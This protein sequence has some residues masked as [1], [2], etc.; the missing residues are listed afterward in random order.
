MW[1]YSRRYVH[2]TSAWDVTTIYHYKDFNSSMYFVV[3]I[4]TARQGGMGSAG[5]SVE[6]WNRHSYLNYQHHLNTSVW[7]SRSGPH[8]EQAKSCIYFFV[9]HLHKTLTIHYISHKEC[10]IRKYSNHAN[11]LVRMFVLF[12]SKS[13]TWRITQEKYPS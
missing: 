7:L 4:V 12:F 3:S 10:S 11:W 8:K 6:N 1:S 5:E 9:I 2:I 13:N